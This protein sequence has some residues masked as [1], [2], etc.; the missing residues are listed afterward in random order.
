MVCISPMNIKSAIKLFSVWYSLVICIP[1]LGLAF[2]VG[3]R[4]FY[5]PAIV[6]IVNGNEQAIEI[7]KITIKR[8]QKCDSEVLDG[9][10]LDLSPSQRGYLDFYASRGKL[11]ISFEYKKQGKTK[12]DSCQINVISTVCSSSI[13]VTS[14]GLVCEPCTHF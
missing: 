13:Y 6:E 7:E 1:L 2:F 8:C 12:K 10:Q 11:T 3:I 14:N 9:S 5:G 4:F